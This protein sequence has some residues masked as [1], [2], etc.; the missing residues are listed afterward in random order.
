M[1]KKEESRQLIKSK[2]E[3]LFGESRNI[4]LEWATGCGKSYAAINLQSQM[5]S[6]KTF[7]CVAET[8]HI[9]NW[10]DEYIKP[11]H[12]ELLKTTEIFCYAS[13]KK[14]RDKSCDLLILDEMHHSFSENKI[15]ILSTI[16]A[17]SVIGLSATISIEQWGLFVKI[18]GNTSTY[19]ISLEEAI[20]MEILP[21]PKVF[22]IPL[23]LDDKKKNCI[24]EYKRGRNINTIHCNYDQ[25]NVY[26]FNKKK[27]PT[28]DLVIHCTEKDKYDYF[29]AQYNW[30]KSTRRAGWLRYGGFRK[31]VLSE[32]KI[33]YIKK[34]SNK[35][36]SEDKRF[37]CFCGSIDQAEE[38]G[39]SN[40]I[41][42]KKEAKEVICKFNNYE[43]DSIYA[44]S[45]LKEGQNL[46]GIDAAIIGQLDGGER[47]FIQKSGR[48]LRAKFPEIYV[49]YF[50]STKDEDYLQNVLDNIPEEY[51][52]YI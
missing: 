23:T 12:E 46:P 19:R 16:N 43:I 41:H 33:D 47:A 28:L 14:Y 26:I 34:L 8:A 21:K 7:I 48:G 6:R 1:T 36:I 18:F 31:Q 17:N 22:I 52:S 2:C 29:D 42:S 30:A 4:I 9:Q 15:D 38:I 11:G 37:I 40:C 45:M 5:N 3:E 10:K 39:G 50:K 51:I 35:L 13:V 49:L 24:I 32:L 25:R 44:V 27:Y 20:E